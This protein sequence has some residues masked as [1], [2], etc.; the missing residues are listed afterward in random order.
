M[1]KCE[2]FLHPSN[3]TILHRARYNRTMPTASIDIW[4]NRL[5]DL[6]R[7]NRLLHLRAGAS[8][9]VE[10]THPNAAELFGLLTRRR[11]LEFVEALTPE[12]RLDA[13]SWDAPATGATM[14]LDTVAAP[15]PRPEQLTTDLPPAEQER[16]LYNLRLRSRTALNE[17][18][19]NLLF[20]A[21]GFLEWMVPGAGEAFWRSPLLLV[22]VELNRSILAGR[23]TLQLADDDIT[24]NPTLRYKLHKEFGLDLPALPDDP[25]DLALEPWFAQVEAAIAGRDGWQL[26]RECAL[27]MF[28]F[29]KLLMYH[30][31]ERAAEQASTHPIVQLLSGNGTATAASAAEDLLEAQLAPPETEYALDARPPEY[32]YQ[33][34]DA[35]SS[36]ATA[37][38]AA[39]TGTSFVLQGPPGTGKSQTIA[40]I[41]A[42]LLADGK[43]VLFVSEKMAALQ[44]VYDRLAQCG[45]EEFCLELHSHKATKR[46]VL[47]TLSTALTDAPPPTDPA[48]PYAE[49]AQARDQ[50][51]MYAQALHLPDPVLGW[52]PF[53]VQGRLGL[54]ADAPD[55]Q[56]PIGD[57][58]S[59]TP[60]R[61]GAV[62]ALLA[63]LD[64]RAELLTAMPENAWRGCSMTSSSFEGRGQVRAH[65]RALQS[66]LAALQRE[67]GLATGQ[68]GT[69]PAQSP[70][71]V[72]GLCNLGALLREPITVPA[73]WLNDE[74]AATRVALINEAAP[75][76][77]T[78]NALEQRL[79]TRYQE[80]VLG[81]DLEG[82]RE[83][84]A[85]QHNSWARILRPQ[86]HRDIAELRTHAQPGVEIAPESAEA[87]LQLAFEV[88]AARQWTANHEPD[89]T[90]QLAPHF[91]GSATD[92]EQLAAS[93]DWAARLSDLP[94]PHP[95]PAPI[96]QAA[97]QLPTART[98][99]LAA[100]DQLGATLPPLDAE[101][102]FVRDLQ[103]EQAT[104]KPD[105][106]E[107]ASFARLQTQ[108]T[109][110]LERMGELDQWWEYCEL[111]RA[112]Q[113]LGM[114]DFLDALSRAPAPAAQ[115]RRAFYKRFCQAWLDRAYEQMP[116]LR[117]FERASYEALVE[118]FRTL[119]REQLGA[120]RQ[121]L[122][123]LLSGRRPPTNSVAPP[124]SELAIL[125]RELQKQRRHKPIRQLFHEIPQL[126]GQIKPCLL[127]SPLSI[128]QF[129]DPEL[130]PFDLVIFDE[131]SQIRTED[132][133]G[134]I[135]RGRALI[136][137]GDNRQLPPTSFFS[138]D[139]TPDEDDET[140]SEEIF[141]SILDA[142]SAAGLPT[143]LLRWHYR[144]RDEALITFSNRQFYSARLAT[145]P[146]AYSAPGRGVHLEH[147]PDG[148]YDRQGSR[149]NPI[150]ARRVADLVI[151]HWRA[152][153]EQ[154]LG[155]VT[156]SQAQQLAVLH[157][158]ERSRAA[159]ETLAPLFDENRP[160]PFFVKNL[161]N[162]QGDERDAMII[163]VGYG[164]DA[165]G[166]VLM[167]FGPLNQLGGE[168]RL[169]V[170]ITRAR[171]RVTV[172]SSLLP[173]DIDVR[174]V[175][176]PG[177]RL[178][179]E[180]LDYA[181]NGGPGGPAQATNGVTPQHVSARPL[182]Q[183]LD[184]R[185]EDRLAV[186]LARRGLQLARQI[187]HSDFRIDIAVRDPHNP[188]QFVL[189]IECDGDDYRTAATARDRERLREQ[190]L[191]TLGWHIHR[192]WSAAW[193]RDPEA[194]IER[195][196]AALAMATDVSK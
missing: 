139:D 3:L 93:A 173:E 79:L 49:L 190:V 29:L 182:A 88:R 4:K 10:L 34:L 158:L 83:R 104:W 193:A 105:T 43:R 147:V 53:Q 181:R 175:Q 189:G 66:A 77:A 69:P 84:F 191:S 7:R 101:L 111:Q 188:Q 85:T 52:T 2:Q 48:F 37:I 39:R 30:D 180:Y 81:I 123:R 8:S 71:E 122:R 155:V 35:D 73:D 162:V 1:K 15:K 42:E 133:I 184:P 63:R 26:S 132:A 131:A 45:L 59:Y 137:V 145:F 92:W 19:I 112:A 51:N 9:V 143:R 170:A 55:T 87:D 106:I 65:L 126:L 100:I 149:S 125:R 109:Q 12:Q 56:A 62:D 33:V 91:A 153:P 178:L 80:T 120:T 64:A 72:R 50:L 47:D 148:V 90:V 11:K 75:H 46:A 103:L 196:A 32:C 172:V 96:V 136:V 98:A 107:H 171:D 86:F 124:S 159:D 102:A 95:L 54:L 67:A 78:L 164:R 36:Q 195:A 41:I 160:E 135:M 17:Q 20:V 192:A 70:A 186:A 169:N 176:N 134:A 154:S 97:T 13:L 119:D 60:E 38:A 117:R 61:M 89:L 6:S 5:L 118:R 128:S 185:F 113:P 156:F 138:T 152:T 57:L 27:G 127:M 183:S 114:A 166:R 151:A 82:L 94:L 40:N 157:A 144:S 18:G 187:G 142:T 58:D 110:L 141:E 174:R 44:V 28:S 21:V 130:P 165:A 161:E 140:A 108:C 76:Y 25:D 31:L 146:N 23:Y 14:Q 150:E 24:L 167:N 177:P 68:L 194:E 129:L 99:L 116:V 121:R 163:S 74:Y 179:R 115:P 16:A 168:R 22:P